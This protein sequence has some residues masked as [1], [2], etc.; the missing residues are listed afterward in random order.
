M[1]P[2]LSTDHYLKLLIKFQMIPL[3]WLAVVCCSCLYRQ[4]DIKKISTSQRLVTNSS[5]STY[6]RAICCAGSTPSLGWRQRPSSHRHQLHKRTIALMSTPFQPARKQVREAIASTFTDVDAN[7]DGVI[8]KEASWQLSLSF[9]ER[10]DLKNAYT[11]L[12]LSTSS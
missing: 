10:M 3:I 8:T 5:V 2:T 9:I 4:N 12:L 1:V 11:D 7:K 6:S